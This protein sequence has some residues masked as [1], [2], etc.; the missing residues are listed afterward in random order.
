YYSENAPRGEGVI[1]LSPPTLEEISEEKILAA[2]EDAL[3]KMKLKDASEV[4]AEKFNLSKKQ[5]YEIGLK[6]KC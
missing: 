4:V 6:L 3:K 1:L 2:L 5:V